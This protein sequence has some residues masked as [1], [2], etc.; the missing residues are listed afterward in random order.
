MVGGGIA[1]LSAAY[2]VKQSGKT[3]AVLEK[4]RIGGGTT[5]HTTGKV[6]SQHNLIYKE[7]TDR[8]GKE[9]ARVYGQA[10]QQALEKIAVVIRKEKIDCGFT[11]ADNYVFTADPE[12][13]KQFKDE[14]KAAAALDLPASFETET[15]LPFHTLCAVK[16]TDQ[17]YFN[18]QAYISGLAAAVNGGGGYVFENTR[19]SVFRDGKRPH[20]RAGGHRV[21]TQDIIVATNVPSLPLMARG[22]YCAMEYPHESYI[23]ACKAPAYPAG[24]YISP[25]DER[26]SILPIE[27]KGERLLLVG[28]S[29]HIPGLGLGADR[30]YKELAEYA[31]T[32]L[33][34]SSVKYRW[35]ARDYLAYDSLPL[36]GKLYPWSRHLY[37]ISA[38][39]KWGLT[40]SMASAVLIRDIINGEPNPAKEFFNPH[41]PSVI[42]SI[43]HA[44]AKS[45]S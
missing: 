29:N 42:K 8:L 5:G 37:V 36:V 23:V 45:F 15:G 26:Y 34:A 13:V 22:T 14:A 9:A 28:G 20:V 12:R 6:T 4:D 19:V 33:N 17:A 21:D 10:N 38:F 31:Q 1:G 7:L 30:H 41:R 35:K 39:R 24:M 11:R 18:A 2:M 25:D 44:I 32:K 27:Y 40:N 43:P 16:F 3:V